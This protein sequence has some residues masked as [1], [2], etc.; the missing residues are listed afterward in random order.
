MARQR[1]RRSA[2]GGPPPSSRCPS[3]SF[4]TAGTMKRAS[5]RCSVLRGGFRNIPIL[6]DHVGVPHA[7]TPETRFAASQGIHLLSCRRRRASASP[8]VSRSSAISACASSKVTDINFD[9][10]EDAALR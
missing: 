6:I 7:S 2:S 8:R 3:L 1:K 4:F 10:L 5:P 9:R